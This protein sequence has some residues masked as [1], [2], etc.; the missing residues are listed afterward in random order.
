MCE[1]QTFFIEKIS[2][3][4]ALACLPQDD[5]QLIEIIRYK[6]I[7]LDDTVSGTVIDKE[8]REYSFF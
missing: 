2:L 8:G 4:P 6:M 3:F 7:I 1:I 5:P